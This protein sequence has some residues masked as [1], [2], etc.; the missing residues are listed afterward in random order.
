MICPGM[1]AVVAGPLRPPGRTV[2]QRYFLGLR[3]ARGPSGLE[4][5]ET[6]SPASPPG[7]KRA[8]RLP[9]AGVRH[10]DTPLTPEK[11]WQALHG[12]VRWRETGCGG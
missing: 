11:I 7:V 10:V 3:G 6:E 9:P 8:A 1:R 4:L 12:N 2:A 5:R